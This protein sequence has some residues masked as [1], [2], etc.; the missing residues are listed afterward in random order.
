MEPL[1]TFDEYLEETQMESEKRG[2]RKGEQ[3]GSQQQALSS[4]KA[5]MEGLN[6]DFDSAADLL[7]IDGDLREY[8]RRQINQKKTS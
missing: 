7:K 4:V 2:I 6:A 1:I 8:C 3:R 5:A